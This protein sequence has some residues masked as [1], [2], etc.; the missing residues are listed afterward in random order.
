MVESNAASCVA[1]DGSMAGALGVMHIDVY[2]DMDCCKDDSHDRTS[3][4]DAN[5]T[6]QVGAQGNLA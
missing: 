3:D 6:L 5:V 4:N 2:G 1:R